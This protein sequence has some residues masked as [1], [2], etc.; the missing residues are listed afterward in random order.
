MSVTPFLKLPSL[1]LTSACNRWYTISFSSL[2]KWSGTL[3]YMCHIYVCSYKCN[4][5]EGVTCLASN[6]LLNCGKLIIS[7]EW[8]IS[9]NQLIDH[10]AKHPPIQGFGITLQLIGW[11]TWVC[12][13]NSVI[14]L[15]VISSGA[16]YSMHP[17]TL[18]LRPLLLL[19][20]PK[21]PS[22]Y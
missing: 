8:R 1:L 3:N 11:I 16:R 13:K 7:K 17:T 4:A 14:T 10:Y 20:N 22:C 21:S 2:E 9:C 5:E 18:Q 15:N 19:A 12:F 6:D